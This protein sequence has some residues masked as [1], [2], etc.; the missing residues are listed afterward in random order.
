MPSRPKAVRST[1]KRRTVAEAPA[2]M[3]R[4]VESPAAPSSAIG[5]ARK[6]AR[7]RASAG[8]T[9]PD[10]RPR[11]TPAPRPAKTAATEA[12]EVTTYPR[13]LRYLA[14]L[15]DF[16]R[17]RIVRYTS[18]NF[19]LGRM[20]TLLKKLGNPHEQFRSVHVAGTKGKGSTCAMT[21]AMLEANGYRVGLYSSPHLI[22]VRERITIGGDLIS[23]VDFTRLVRECEPHVRSMAQ[24]QRVTPTYFDVLTAVAFKYFA[25]KKVDIAVVETGLGGRLDSTNVLTPEVSAVTAISKDHCA[26][27]GHTLA[28]IAGEKGG[29]FKPGVPAVTCEQPPEV[30][31]ALRQ[32]ADEAGA[33]LDVCGKT[34][35]FSYRFEASRMLG[36]HNRVCLTTERSRFEHVSVPLLGEHQAVNLGVA[37]CIIDK[38][39]ARG[40]PIDDV[41]A[42]EGLATVRLAGRMETL[43]LNP[44]VIVDCAHNAASVDAMFKAVGQNVSYDSLV[45]VFGCCSDKDVPGML[46]RITCGAD[47]VIFTRVNNVRSADPHEL[48]AQ[49]VEKY[50]KM[51]QVAQNLEEAMGIARRA[52]GKD[53]LI[54]ITGSFYLVGE[55]K[56]LLQARRK[57][58]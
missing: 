56:R 5:S 28:A 43:G 37:L 34:V 46:Q 48:S 40:L 50:G 33:V 55:A 16:E 15:S 17:M 44:R 21:A 23:Q 7:L 53:D 32:K 8:G 38:L 4:S 41:R 54:V 3:S 27:L 18:Q 30:E 42:A 6:P 26:Q 52:V 10:A 13:A 22:D 24:R 1:P 51:A 31:A 25:E 47:K 39:K 49:Y 19:D 45:V 20:R 29:I 58:A 12:A 36:R 2:K 9:V 35:E 57:S 11:A 14:K